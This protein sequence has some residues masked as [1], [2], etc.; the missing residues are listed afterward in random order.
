MAAAV[1]PNALHAGGTALAHVSQRQQFEFS[2]NPRGISDIDVA[3]A[4]GRPIEELGI[5]GNRRMTAK[6]I[7]ALIKTRAGDLYNADQVQ[8]DLSAILE[9]GYF[10][11][12]GTRVLLDEGVRG[13]VRVLFEV[14]ELPLINEIKFRSLTERDQS[15]IADELHK[16]TVE[17]R[18]GAPLDTAKLKKAVQV[19]EI[20]LAS[21]GWHDLRVVPFVENLSATGGSDNLQGNRV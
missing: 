7:L 11:S 14:F 19:I 15:A 6:Q 10:N 4:A 21:R 8:R 16:Q 9:T 2:I 12:N 1:G 17:I 3:A 13:G 18:K 5:I 20:F